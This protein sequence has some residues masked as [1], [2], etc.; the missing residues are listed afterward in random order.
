MISSPENTYALVVGIE[1]YAQGSMWD[2]DGPADDA[3]RFVQWL[4]DRDVP[5]DH[6][7]QFISPL[8][9]NSGSIES[10]VQ[11]ATRENIHRALFTTLPQKQDGTL[12]Y[13]FWGGHGIVTSKNSRLL[14]YAETTRKYLLNLDLTA[15]LTSLRSSYFTNFEQQIYLIDACGKYVADWQRDELGAIPS[16]SFPSRD[17]DFTHKQYVMLASRAGELAI[18]LDDQ[19]TGLFSQQLLEELRTTDS[20]YWPPNM[21]NIREQL[22][23]RFERL[24]KEGSTAQTP[25]HLWYSDWNDNERSFSTIPTPKIRSRLAQKDIPDFTGRVKELEK[26]RQLLLNPDSSRTT[27]IVGVVG[28]GGMGKSTLVNHFATK[29]KEYFPDG[30]YGL[31]VGRKAADVLA[32]EFASLADA[33][34][35]PQHQPETIMQNAFS[36]RQALLIFDNVEDAAW[37]RTLNP[38]G[39]KC[40]VIVTTRNRGVLAS[41]ISQSMCIDLDGFTFKETEEFFIQLL[42]K[43]R[44]DAELESLQK[45]YHMVGALPLALR[46]IGSALLNQK[47]T[48]L[49]KYSER[50]ERERQ[51]PSLSSFLQNRNDAELNVYASF[52]LSLN[53]LSEDEKLLFACL[54]ACAQEGFSYMTA[55]AVSDLDEDLVTDGMV[56]LCQLSLVNQSTADDRYILH[57]LLFNFARELAKKQAL[58]TI[59]E[60]RHTAYFVAYTQEHKTLF[61]EDSEALERELDALILTGERLKDDMKRA[62]SFYMSLK[63][64]LQSRGYWSRALNWISMLSDA[65]EKEEDIYYRAFCLMQ[66]E[67]FLHLFARYEEAEKVLADSQQLI[68]KMEDERERTELT[69]MLRAKQGGIA[70]NHW[71]NLREAETNFK[72]SL[73]LWTALDRQWE[74]GKALNKLGALYVARGKAQ[75]MQQAEDVLIESLEIFERLNDTRRRGVVLNTLSGL[76]ISLGK[77]DQA[78]WDLYEALKIAEQIGDRRSIGV[79]QGR[80]GGMYRTQGKKEEA[81]KSFQ[82]ALS[83]AQE[84]DDIKGIVIAFKSLQDIYISEGNF[85]GTLDRIHIYLGL[86]QKAKYKEGEATLL[87]MRGEIYF[88]QK[89]LPEAEEAL[90]E[91]LAIAR[92]SLDVNVIVDVLKTLARVYYEQKNYQKGLELSQ[93]SIQLWKKLDNTRSLIDFLLSLGEFY[94]KQTWYDQASMCYE[95]CFEI[96][97][98]EGSPRI[99]KTTIILIN[100]LLLR[101]KKSLAQQYWKRALVITPNDSSLLKAQRRISQDNEKETLHERAEIAEKQGNIKGQAQ[102]LHK[103]GVVYQLENNIDQAQKIFLKSLNIGRQLNYTKHIVIV[104]KSLGEVY[105]LQGNIQAAEEVLEEGYTLANQQENKLGMAKILET[106]GKLLL[107]S[108]DVERATIY[109]QESFALYEELQSSQ[110]INTL[111]FLVMALM[112][113]NKDEE[114]LAYWRRAG[115]LWSGDGKMQGTLRYLQRKISTRLQQSARKTGYIKL[116]KRANAYGP[117]YG[118]I[119]P[120]DGSQDIRFREVVVASELVGRLQVGLRVWADIEMAKGIPLARK[121]GEEADLPANEVKVQIPRV[122]EKPEIAS[123]NLTLHKVFNAEDEKTL[124]SN[125][126][127][128]EIQEK[129]Q[130]L[131][132]LGQLHQSENKLDQ[133]KEEFLESLDIARKLN[134][135]KHIAIVLR[136]LGD[137]YAL[138]GNIQA[139]EEVMEETYIL[140]EQEDNKAYMAEIQRWRGK[141]LLDFGETE[142]AI[143]YLQK[144]FALYEEMQNRQGIKILYVLIRAL[145]ILNEEEEAKAYWQRAETLW[146]KDDELLETLKQLEQ[147]LPK[148]P[149]RLRQPVRKTGHIKRLVRANSYGSSYGFITA[150]DGSQ[151]IYFK[152]EVVAS[153]LVGRLRIGL[154]VWADVQMVRGRSQAIRVE[155]ETGISPIRKVGCVKNLIYNSPTG[156]FYGFI[157]PD[158][159]S[160]DIHFREAVVARELMG[161]LQIGTRVC[162][163]IEVLGTKVRALKVEKE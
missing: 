109:L 67:T 127:I 152:Q 132:K 41:N 98:A 111:R 61:F 69:A 148:L 110:G 32:Q 68:E 151:D 105:A 103:L 157:V 139:A 115:V 114:A 106:R 62:V 149:I 153:E 97:E 45:I 84:M 117:F 37:I 121:V 65:A 82:E 145:T 52:S 70:R 144:S 161:H 137:I 51:K 24:R 43:Q 156:S 8:D 87:N 29:Y 42:G 9:K 71:H 142:R 81:K 1:K 162:A 133:A 158:D 30:V 112:I 125:L 6:I 17:L 74:R 143:I 107:D 18:N 39:E 21:D 104:L 12:L 2:L 147:E 92:A 19:Q 130:I 4:L 11:P 94:R 46:I 95:A 129:A 113:L 100:I 23:T 120:D 77:M 36:D 50:L 7:L 126:E 160:Q 28:T 27:R 83:I 16:E 124:R 150:D 116:L 49:A 118:F 108:N 22:N 35:D 86:V 159:G 72:E 146:P 25:M 78:E 55:Q 34:Y 56:Q 91:A 66:C 54:G 119:T 47:I 123:N 136:S 31:H 38:G 33:P 15:L 13:V 3:H 14:Y 102:I 63:P 101:H 89:Q 138:Q 96:Q 59:A 44:V 57:P 20:E 141:L 75:D 88:S 154:H 90:Q 76:Y 155:K 128:L 93:E 163:D 99:G 60:Q 48:T 135:T 10:D 131:Y 64:L 5:R 79:V 40:A 122:E 140:A 134:L 26:L 80:L 53:F 73:A 58:L 85:Q